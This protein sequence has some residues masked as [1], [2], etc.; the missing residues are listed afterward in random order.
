[1]YCRYMYY[2]FCYMLIINSKT[3]QMDENVANFPIIIT[4][5]QKWNYYKKFLYLLKSISL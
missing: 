2:N 4:L 1:M 3:F 5:D